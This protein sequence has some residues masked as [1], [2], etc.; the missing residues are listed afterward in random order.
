MD[1]ENLMTFIKNNQDQKEFVQA[2][3]I[4]RRFPVESTKDI[5]KESSIELSVSR[6]KAIIG[7]KGLDTVPENGFERL[8]YQTSVNYYF[9]YCLVIHL[10]VIY[11]CIMMD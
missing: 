9:N 5:I 4:E 3:E 10:R 8:K 11:K 1:P 7:L 6:P 2:T